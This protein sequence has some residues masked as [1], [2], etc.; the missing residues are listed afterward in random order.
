MQLFLK[1]ISGMTNSVDP[2]QIAP[3]E[4]SDLGLHRLHMPFCL[5]LRCLKFYD[6]YCNILSLEVTCGSQ[7]HAKMEYEDG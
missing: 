5:K 4:Q 7:M 1:I 6:I 3:E 2:G